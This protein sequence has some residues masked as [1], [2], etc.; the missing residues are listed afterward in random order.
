M[1][2]EMA[3]IT[4]VSLGGRLPVML[5]AEATLPVELIV[6]GKMGKINK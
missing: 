5:P 3:K 4:R 6:L 2:P 1:K